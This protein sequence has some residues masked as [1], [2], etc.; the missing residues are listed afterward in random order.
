M[1]KMWIG[2]VLV[3]MLGCGASAFADDG[4]RHDRREIRGDQRDLRNDYREIAHDRQELYRDRVN[5]N[6]RAAQR[7]RARNQKRLSRNP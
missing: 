3:V 2:V 1:K 6:Y 7:E 5:G 4:W